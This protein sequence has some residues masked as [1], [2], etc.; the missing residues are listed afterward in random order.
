MQRKPLTGQRILLTG[1]TGSLGRETALALAGL[2]ASL[3]LPARNPDKA[4]TLETYLL[5]AFPQADIRFLSMDMA[6]EQSVLSAVK[7]LCDE[8]QPLHA[9]IHN[10][11]VFT[12]AGLS[13]PQGT[14]WHRQVNTL[15]PLL[16]TRELLPLLQAAENPVV[17]TVTSLSAFWL[18][19]PETSCENNR[20]TRLY[21]ESKHQLL[22]E[23]FSL[24]RQHVRIR[25]VYAHPGVCAS[26][27]FTG[28]THQTAYNASFLKMALPL[29]KFIF[30]SPEKAC[31]TTLHALLHGQGDQLAEPGGFLHIWGRPVLVPLTKRL[32]TIRTSR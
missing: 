22:S 5:N 4:K 25:F 15:S 13:S 29:M 6:D 12:K 20:P 8:K 27:L 24:S 7:Q 18:K 2:G 31:R 14:E 3:I 17:V 9:I 10:A 28:D 11:G 16:L 21:A 1:A 26:G 30:P 23:M 32:K 19:H